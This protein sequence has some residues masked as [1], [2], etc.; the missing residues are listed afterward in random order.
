M[1]YLYFYKTKAHIFEKMNRIKVLNKV[2]Y[3]LLAV[4]I[5]Y[6]SFG[7]LLLYFPVRTVIKHSVFKSI[8]KKEIAK[9]DLVILAFNIDD[10]K[11]QKYDLIWK[12]PDKEFRFNG[13]MYDI[14]DTRIASDTIYYTCYNDVGEN[15][16]EGLFSLH[17]QNHKKDGTQNTT[18]RLIL[19]GLYLEEIENSNLKFYDKNVINIP[20]LKKEASNLNPTEDIPTPPPR[21]IV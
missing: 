1:I 2:V 8:E 19:I 18:Q 7:Y 4:L 11:N 10:L 16:L 14:E 6:S 15:L 12:K 9:E 5:I 17:I 3:A 20:L 13:Q 21:L